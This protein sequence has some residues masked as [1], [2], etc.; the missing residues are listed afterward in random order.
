MNTLPSTAEHGF[1]QVGVD[2]LLSEPDPEESHEKILPGDRFSPRL[3]VDGD[4][5]SRLRKEIKRDD[6]LFLRASDLL[7]GS[8]QRLDA[9][10]QRG[11]LGHLDSSAFTRKRN[12]R[13]KQQGQD[14]A[15]HHGLW[16]RR[17]GTSSGCPSASAAVRRPFAVRNTLSRSMSPAWSMLISLRVI[18][19]TSTSICSSM[20]RTVRGL[21]Q[22]LI[23]GRIGLPIT[24]P[25][26][27][28]KKCT[29]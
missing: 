27:V 7:H 14:Q 12:R 20:R 9:L 8:D 26:P 21:A 24:F 11:A 4:P 19:E 25:C 29:A 15:V 10:L 28:G 16:Y 22:S 2:R 3:A 1:L 5:R 6:R 23:T 18:P 13:G 17:V